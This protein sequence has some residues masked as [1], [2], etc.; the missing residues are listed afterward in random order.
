MDSNKSCRSCGAAIVFLVTKKGKIVPVNQETVKPEDTLY[1]RE[2][3]VSHF[4]TCPAADT[5]RAGG[6]AKI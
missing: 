5:F 6:E 1:D 2:R 3:H 4:S